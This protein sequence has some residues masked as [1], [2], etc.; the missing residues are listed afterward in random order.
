ME[1]NERKITFLYKAG[2][3][4]LPD[5]CPYCDTPVYP[6]E[7]CCEKCRKNLKFTEYR[8]YAKGGFPCTSTFPYVEQYKAAVTRFKFCGRKQ[9]AYSM[10][11]MMADTILREYK[12]IDFDLITYVPIH[13]LKLKE[14]GYNQ[15]KL[16]AKN[17]SRILNIPC[18]ATLVKTRNTVPQFTIKKPGQREKN[19]KGAFRVMNQESVKDSIKNKRILLIDDIITT[20]STMGECAKALDKCTPESIHCVTFAIS[21]VKTT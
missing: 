19:V 6:G 5:R 21:V 18:A 13:R 8:T 12:S 9:Y 3:A 2:C 14:R 17:L 20:G 15:C 10:A 7:L 4:F 11:R 16:L 1:I